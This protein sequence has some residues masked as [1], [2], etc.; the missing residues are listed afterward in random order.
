V[1]VSGLEL[2][3]LAGSLVAGK[4]SDRLIAR[5]PPGAGHVGRRL[6]VVRAAA[7][8]PPAPPRSPP[9]TTRRRR[10]EAQ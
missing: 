10:V 1:R 2:G 6:I 9:A 3:G 7:A 4:L 8:R 5:A